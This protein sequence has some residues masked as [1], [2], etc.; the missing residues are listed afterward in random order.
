[1][2]HTD[3]FT[4]QYRLR[5]GPGS[6]LEASAPYREFL[7]AFIRAHGVRSVVDLGCGDFVVM[8]AT[9]LMG[10]SYR[11]IDCIEER[12]EANRAKAPGVRFDVGDLTTYPIPRA[13]LL[14][15]K[16]VLQHWAT[17]DVQEWLAR[18]RRSP[19]WCW[20]LITNCVSGP[21]PVNGDIE[22]GRWRNLDLT[23]PP[24]EVGEVVFGWST[25]QVVLL[26]GGKKP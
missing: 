25:K 18:L 2:S 19:T 6:T 13:D 12:I 23:A 16:D 20:A 4:P 14:L 24:F 5:S 21:G 26:H 9:D 10:A 7:T 1:M 11:G 17:A 8:G 15:C 3:I 22:T